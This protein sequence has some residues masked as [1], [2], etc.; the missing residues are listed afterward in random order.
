MLVRPD[1][2]AELLTLLPGLPLGLGAGGEPATFPWR[3]GDR[4]LLY[5]DGLSEAR[6]DRGQFLPLLELAPT[7]SASP[8]DVA[9][10]NVLEIVQRHIKGG[11]LGDDLALVL[12][13]NTVGG[14]PH[15]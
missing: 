2:T 11:Q 4:V 10:D 13:E 3:A 9:L 8:P 15:I 7:L 6:D 14:A 12:L 5:T 1:G